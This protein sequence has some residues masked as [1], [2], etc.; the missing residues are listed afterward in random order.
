MFFELPTKGIAKKKRIKTHQ[1]LVTSSQ[2]AVVFFFVFLKTIPLCSTSKRKSSERASFV[3]I[4]EACNYA[5]SAEFHLARINIT[6]PASKLEFCARVNRIDTIAPIL[7]RLISHKKQKIG[8][9]LRQENFQK[10]HIQCLEFTLLIVY[11]IYFCKP[12]LLGIEC[13]FCKLFEKLKSV[14]VKVKRLKKFVCVLSH[15]TSF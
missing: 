10:Y 14:S 9:S 2:S 7:F 4:Y 15:L 5:R 3:N 6:T 13:S 12:K 11:S 1:K 8:F